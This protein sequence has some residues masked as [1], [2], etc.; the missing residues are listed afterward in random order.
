MKPTCPKCLKSQ[1]T[2][3]IFSAVLWMF[4]KSSVANLVLD[5]LPSID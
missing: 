3:V 1:K 2:Y 5:E 4:A